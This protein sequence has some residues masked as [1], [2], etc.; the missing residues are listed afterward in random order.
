MYVKSVRLETLMNN[1]VRF[2]CFNASG[3]TLKCRSYHINRCDTS[4][5]YVQ[6][7]YKS[8]SLLSFSFCFI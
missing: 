1:S 4:I 8:V 6:N 2:N 3:T 5:L 7:R